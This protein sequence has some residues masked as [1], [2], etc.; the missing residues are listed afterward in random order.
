MP[1]IVYVEDDE[2]LRDIVMMSLKQVGFDVVSAEN[3]RDG[4][5]VV[6]DENPDLVIT[7]LNMPEEDG[8]SLIRHLVSLRPGLPIVAVTAGDGSGLDS[9]RDALAEEAVRAGARASLVKPFRLQHLLEVVKAHLPAG[10]G[11]GAGTRTAH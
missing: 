6:A 4:R 9:A 2:D 11:T 3:G 10:D 7:D 5:R 1:R 8:V